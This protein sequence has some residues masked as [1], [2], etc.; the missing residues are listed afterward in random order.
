LDPTLSVR[1]IPDSADDAVRNRV[2]KSKGATDSK[3]MLPNSHRIR[4][5]QIQVRKVLAVHLQHRYIVLWIVGQHTFYWKERAAIQLNDRRRRPA[6]YMV[7][8]D[9]FAVSR[10][11]EATAFRDGLSCN[12]AHDDLHDS[13]DA[14]L[15]QIA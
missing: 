1:L 9:D 8:R 6:D 5:R 10:H 11:D 2:L 3:H 13:I 4:V 15:D 7:I 14:R 12:I